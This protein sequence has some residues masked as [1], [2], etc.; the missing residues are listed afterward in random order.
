MRQARQRIGRGDSGPRGYPKG[1]GRVVC[2]RIGAL[3]AARVNRWVS[4]RC[5][6][7][8]VLRRC[9][10][11]YSWVHRHTRSSRRAFRPVRSVSRSSDGMS[12]S[13]CAVRFGALVSVGGDP[14]IL[15]RT[16]RLPSVALSATRRTDLPTG[17]S[18]GAAPPLVCMRLSYSNPP[19]PH[20]S[21]APDCRSR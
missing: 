7:V 4:L 13:P 17:Q 18:V 11:G 2:V 21:V 1:I 12:S 5:G 10:G 8:A 19:A 16:R 3:E 14:V 9:C 15:F 20:P 6:H